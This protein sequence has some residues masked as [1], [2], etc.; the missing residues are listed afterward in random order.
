MT[1]RVGSGTKRLRHAFQRVEV[2]AVGTYVFEQLRKRYPCGCAFF[3]RAR[4]PGKS[5]EEYF[6]PSIMELLNH[7]SH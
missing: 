4:V 6:D 7:F 5:W 3:A 2:D 1:G